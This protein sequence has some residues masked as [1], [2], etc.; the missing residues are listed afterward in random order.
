MAQTPGK[1]DFPPEDVQTVVAA[2]ERDFLTAVHLHFADKEADDVTQF[3]FA[4]IVLLT[5]ISDI[6]A[7]DPKSA[8]KNAR[9]FGEKLVV[10]THTR[11]TTNEAS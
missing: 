8:I 6:L 9:H 2:L 4:M 7:D 10:L 1:F 3:A 5:F 11:L